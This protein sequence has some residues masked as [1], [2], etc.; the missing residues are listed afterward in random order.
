M[1]AEHERFWEEVRGK[2]RRAHDL[3][4]LCQEESEKEYKKASSQPLSDADVEDVLG[5]VRSMGTRGGMKPKA[6]A[7]DD[8]AADEDGDIAAAWED[9]VTDEMMAGDLQLINRNA[10][11]KDDETTDLVDKLR[12][13]ALEEAEGGEEDGTADQDKPGPPDGEDAS[14]TGE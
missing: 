8:D 1:A 3:D 12:Q 4:P 11:D 5:F 2:L 9:P 6:D 10:G 7:A 14:G 13:Q